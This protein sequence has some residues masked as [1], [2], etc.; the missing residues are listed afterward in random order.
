LEANPDY[1]GEEPEMQQVTILFMEEDAAFLAAQAGEVDLAYTSATY[2]DQEIDGYEL[3][4]YASVDNRGFNL[5]AVE[6][7]TDSEGRTVGNDFTSDV[8]VRRAINIGIDR[9]EMIDNVLNGYGSPAYSVCD[10]LPWYN[11]A[12]EVEYD[13]EGAAALF[14][15]AGWTVG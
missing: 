8:L 3:T 9:Q 2:S 7:S 1:Y 6:E 4:A 12:S 14:D 5:P 15:E 11:E 13:P 10:Q